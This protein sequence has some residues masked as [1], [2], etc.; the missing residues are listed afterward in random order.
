M[1]LRR[2]VTTALLA[3]A[4]ATA[5]IAPTS[6]FAESQ[7]DVKVQYIAGALV[8]DGSDGTYYVTIPSNVLFSNVNDTADMSVNLMQVDTNKE[9]DPNL[10]VQVDVYSTNNYKLTNPNYS[11]K[12]GT[13]TL[14]YLA[15]SADAADQ[16]T[17]FAS[18]GTVMANNGDGSGLAHPSAT[19]GS[20][21][22]TL[23]PD[24]SI[25]SGQAKMTIEPTVDTQGV[26][27][28]DTLTYYVTET[29][30]TTN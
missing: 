19:N 16:D 18:G 10:E 12:D 22:G 6:V 11:G 21:V 20:V 26:S 5:V 9:L 1:A 4:V 2:R 30:S 25:I 3:G 8:P 7:G 24:A 23:T 13:Y 27:F 17:G 14:T 15:P 28:S 29:A